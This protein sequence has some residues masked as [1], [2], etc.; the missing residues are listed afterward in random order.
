MHAEHAIAA[1]NAGKH[2]IVTKPL[3][4]DLAHAPA[5][6]EAQRRTGRHLMVGQSSR[7]IHPMQA[8]RADLARHGRIIAV[9]AHYHGD[10]RWFYRQKSWSRGG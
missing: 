8:Q 5:L 6:I 4:V 7:F 10:H 9:E 1:L 2:V 3:I